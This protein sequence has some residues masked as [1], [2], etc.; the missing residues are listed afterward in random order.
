MEIIDNYKV[1]IHINKI[2]NKKYVGITKQKPER[3]WQN[4]YGYKYNNNTH[5]WN[6]IKKYG[7]DNFKHEIIE[8]NLSFE[9]AK[10]M[11]RYY[12]ALYN[13][14]QI[15]YGYNLTMGGDGFSGMNRCEETKKKISQSLKGKYT[16]EKSYWYG[17]HISRDI[18]E[19]QK[20]T[21]KNN[22]YHHTDE[23]KK[24]HSEQLKGKNHIASKPVRCKNTGELFVNSREAAEF[25]HT[26][27]SRIHKCCKGI[28]K[29][30]GKHPIT[31]EKLLW[32]YVDDDE[33]HLHSLTLKTGYDKEHPR[34]EIEIVINEE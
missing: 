20:E 27:N 16:K 10:E 17:K 24:K 32:E 25:Y 15:D 29:S 2:N 34:T 12:I 28:E 30:S 23:W 8:S 19:K 1:Y 9:K 31:G 6:A 14:N 21:K 33:K 7:W 5:F 11:E 4:G 18:I 3:R 26:D 22:P 13:S